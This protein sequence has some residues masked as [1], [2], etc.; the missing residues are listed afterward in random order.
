MLKEWKLMKSQ[1][2]FERGL[3]KILQKSHNKP[4][5]SEKVLAYV[6]DLLDWVN[7]VGLNEDGNILLIKQFR[8]GTDKIELEIPGDI[9]EFGESPKDGAIRELKEETGY[10]VKNIKRIGFVDANPAI[11]NNKCFTN[12]ATLSDKGEVNFD[13]DEIIEMEFESPNQVKKLLKEGKITNAYSVLA[14]Q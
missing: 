10:N 6:L 3:F 1:K 12:L 14:L 4:D 5:K 7:I 9:V 11:M 13:P 2:I 8:F